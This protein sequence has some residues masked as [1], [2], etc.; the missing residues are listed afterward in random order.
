MTITT[1]R[2]Q[3]LFP[4]VIECPSCD[5]CPLFLFM[6]IIIFHSIQTIFHLTVLQE[7]MGSIMFMLIHYF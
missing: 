3:V 5:L 7:N 4:F 2:G 6:L 1:Q